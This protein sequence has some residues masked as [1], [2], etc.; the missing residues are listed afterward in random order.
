M[1]VLPFE[2]RIVQ[3][4]VL[5]AG[6]GENRN[7]A[8]LSGANDVGSFARRHVDDVELATGRLAP[9]DRALDR[10]RLDEIRARHR[11]Q[12]RAVLLH[13]LRRVMTRDQLVE[14]SRRFGVHQQHRAVLLHLLERA[15]HRPVVGLPAFGFIDHEF[16]EGGEAPIHHALDLILVLVPARDANVKGVVDE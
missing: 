14:H 8:R 10:F 12:A 11:V 16:L 5:D 9:L 1:S 4:Q 7:A 6:L 2:N 15:E 3:H 13:Q